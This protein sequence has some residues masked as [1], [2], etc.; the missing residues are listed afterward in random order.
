MSAPL[1]YWQD[2]YESSQGMPAGVVI[3]YKAVSGRKTV[4][5][6]ESM[7]YSGERNRLLVWENGECVS[8]RVGMSL[9]DGIWGS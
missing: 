6:G 3:W 2:L 7:Y 1:L 5:M 8:C 9:R 4:R